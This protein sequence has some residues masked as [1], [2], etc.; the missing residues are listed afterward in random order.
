MGEDFNFGSI[1]DESEINDLFS[2]GEEAKL[3]EK[4]NVNKEGVKES[5]NQEEEKESKESVTEDSIDNLFNPEGVG[6]DK[7]NTEEREGS[8]TKTTGASPNNF[9]S[10][11]KALKEDGPLSS[12]DDKFFDTIKDAQGFSDAIEEEVKNRLDESQRRIL[13]ALDNNIE[14]D[15]IRQYEST[16]RYLDSI[17]DEN[18]N[19]ES[20]KGV[21][22]RKALIYQDF[23]NKGYSKEKATRMLN[24]IVSDGTDIEDAKDALEANRKYYKDSYND[25]RDEAKREADAKREEYRKID[26][27]LKKSIMDDKEVIN[28]IGELDRTTRQKAYDAI[29]KPVYKDNNTGRVYSAVQKFEKD[30]PVEFRKVMGLVYALTDGYKSFDSLVKSKV[31]KEKKK[32]IAELE[33][34]I[35]ST[36]RNG[37]GTF[38]LANGGGDDNSFLDGIVALDL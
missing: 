18:L 29:S 9:S 13:E 23:I 10:I 19:D 37:D 28:G 25:L 3:E 32:G 31:E 21:E 15:D 36:P 6:G 27:S 8:S 16:L 22:L 33:R 24:K 12:V 26:E 17:T 38:R 34:V 2:S 14:P 20:D 30:N 5:Q 7:K 35:N 1:L 11:A 4:P